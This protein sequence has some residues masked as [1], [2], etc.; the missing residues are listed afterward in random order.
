MKKILLIAVSTVAACFSFAQ[1]GFTVKA[2]I[3]NPENYKLSLGYF[4]NAKYNIDTNYVVEN[5]WCIFKGT[6]SEPTEANLAVIKNPVLMIKSSKGVIPGPSLNF[7]LSNDEITIKGD[8]NTIYTA[9]VKGGK[10]NKEWNEIK[11][12]ED[13]SNH[14]NW[15][16][17]KESYESI[18]NS[19]DSTL[20]KKYFPE[21]VA[22]SKELM[23]LHTKF[24]K[25]NPNSV[26]SAYFLSNMVNTLDYD[27]LKTA[28]NNLHESVKSSMYA[29]RIAAKIEA[30]DA[31]ATGKE[32]IPVSKKD[33]SGNT[34]N[35]QTLK[36]KYVLLDFWG[37]WCGP[38]RMSH[39]H[40][41]EL[42][43]KY[44]S[45]GFE[46]LGIAQENNPDLE[47]CR[48]SWIEAIKKD[49]I[50]WIQV[51]NNED[52]DKFDAVKSYGV[53]AFPTKILL[54]KDGK[55]VARYVG[56]GGDELDKKLKQ[57]FG[58]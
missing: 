43:S 13:E 56:F 24:I 34:V 31:T 39:P 16:G 48:Q 6:V 22:R 21:G 15:V 47:K 54:D 44:K 38:C 10:E 3:N 35:L 23:A 17:M 42:Y 4:I 2:K 57:V 14:K 33:I 30:M 50:S 53:T 46:I 18:Y 49:G 9:S 26:V 40:L 37:S 55:V 12:K 58:N 11:K 19:G 29:K 7:F 51:L 45:Q 41:K 28:Y 20:Y 27:D 1:K 32:A 52:I 5:G 25:K 36:G 8:A